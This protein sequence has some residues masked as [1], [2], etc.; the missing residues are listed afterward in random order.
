MFAVACPKCEKQLNL[1]E[2]SRGKRVRCMGCQEIVLATLE[3]PPGYSTPPPRRPVPPP[4]P[5]PAP[6]PDP[7]P[8]TRQ[9]D[10]ERAA[11]AVPEALPGLSCPSCEAAAV[12]ELPPDADSRRPGF[13]CAMCRTPMRVPGTAGNYYAATILG[14]VFALLGAGLLAVGTNAVHGRNLLLGSGAAVAVLGLAVAAWAWNVARRPV[15]VGLAPA[16][17][18]FGF[19]L[20]ISLVSAALLGGGTFALTY[21]VKVVM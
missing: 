8:T 21:L 5:A 16:P 17:A 14:V 12:L 7:Y 11:G 13:V 19:W 18:R 2:T 6:S 1:P 20:V 4:V 9:R 10:L 15:P 3:P